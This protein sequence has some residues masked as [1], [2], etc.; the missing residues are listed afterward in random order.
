MITKS[1]S[2][3]RSI[4]DN[5]LISTNNKINDVCEVGKG[6]APEKGTSLSAKLM[7]VKNI[8]V[9]L[10]QNKTG[11]N[12][13]SH[14]GAFS[15][16]FTKGRE[17]LLD[18]SVVQEKDHIHI[19]FQQ[20]INHITDSLLPQSDVSY[21]SA[22]TLFQN[23]ASYHNASDAEKIKELLMATRAEKEQLQD[24][25]ISLFLR[26]ESINSVTEDFTDK[27]QLTLDKQ[28]SLFESIFKV[29]YSF[30]DVERLLDASS[31]KDQF[32]EFAS[33]DENKNKLGDLFSGLIKNS[34]RSLQEEMKK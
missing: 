19:N 26:S 25:A 30:D 21:Q 3:P 32:L 9:F 15:G 10:A 1:K 14:F 7:E 34:V 29:S 17:S 6:N 2:S 28:Y 11:E 5:A 20:D 16:D 4:Q 33:Q 31:V 8:D 27:D 22:L 18:N 13:S 24:H 23:I 12:S